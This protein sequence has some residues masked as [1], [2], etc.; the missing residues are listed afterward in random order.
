MRPRLLFILLALLVA[1]CVT[2]GV[3]TSAPAGQQTVV[4]AQPREATYRCEDGSSIRIENLRSLVRLTDAEGETYELPASP[5]D[6]QS[7][8]VATP[9]AL[10]LDGEEALWMAG[11]NSPATCRR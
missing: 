7:R 6:S 11:R 5:P 2:E 8:Y 1:G 3:Q 10:V 4:A 9:N